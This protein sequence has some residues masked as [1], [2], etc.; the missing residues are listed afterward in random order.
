MKFQLDY[1]LNIFSFPTIYCKPTNLS[2]RERPICLK[3]GLE[4]ASKVRK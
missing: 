2:E 4:S 1:K 3:V